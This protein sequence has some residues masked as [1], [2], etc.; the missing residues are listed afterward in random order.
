MMGQAATGVAT[1]QGRT[2]NLTQLPIVDQPAFDPVT[3]KSNMKEL[4]R[5]RNRNLI[6]RIAQALRVKTFGAPYSTETTRPRRF[7]KGGNIENFGPNKTVVSGPSSINYDDRFGNVPLNGYVLNQGASL[8]PRN[9]DLVDAAPSTFSNSGSTMKAMLTPKETIFG[10]GI[11][12]NPELYAAVDAANNGYAF[13]GNIMRNKKNYGLIAAR[14]IV[15]ASELR[16]LFPGLLGKSHGKN[17][18][19]FKGTQGVFGGNVKDK[20]LVE[21]NRVLLNI[22]GSTIT[23]SKINKHM[24][25][26]G[27]PPE[28]LLASIAA[29]RGSSRLSTDHLL[30][31]LSMSGILSIQQRQELSD[32]AFDHYIGSLSKLKLVN[33]HNNPVLESSRKAIIRSTSI[34]SE[35]RRLALEALDIFAATPGMVSD[36]SSRG[37]SGYLKSIVLSD[38]TVVP[39]EK[40]KGQGAESFFHA[41]KPDELLEKFNVGGNIPGGNIKKGRSKYNCDN[42]ATY[43]PIAINAPLPN[44]I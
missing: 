11:H 1:A 8:D 39:L 23:R 3:G 9:K 33:D 25:K 24:E 22:S 42:T 44:E 43:A 32:Q 26:D 7:N 41:P 27:V 31:G 4:T 35:Q 40:L 19:E 2:I 5:P 16:R 17:E 37:T 38:G 29:R 14:A 36:V 12:R 30:D 10:P 20:D 15:K 18:Y 13:G 28:V 34:S 21:A 6:T